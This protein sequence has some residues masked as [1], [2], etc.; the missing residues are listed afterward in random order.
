MKH[1]WS[2]G[3]GEATCMRAG[4]GRKKTAVNE[5]ADDCGVHAPFTS[6]WNDP[7]FTGQRM[8]AI[9]QEEDAWIARKE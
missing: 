6:Y 7:D 9:R 4:C 2:N 5:N 8:R 3:E 1:L